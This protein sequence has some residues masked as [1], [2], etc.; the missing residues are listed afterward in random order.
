MATGTWFGLQRAPSHR[1]MLATAFVLT[2][3][4]CRPAQAGVVQ[5]TSSS[6][7]SSGDSSLGF[8]A[9]AGTVYA[10]HSV[11]FSSGS[12]TVGFGNTS[13]NGFEVDQANYNY[14]DTAFAN[15]TKLLGS[16]GY[17]GSGG[18]LTVTFSKAVA[19]FGFN[20]EDFY[21]G[22]YT[23]SFTA[24]NGATALGTF[25]ASGCDTSDGCTGANKLSFEGLA[26]SGGTQI[27][28]LV[29]TDDGGQN[30]LMLGNFEFGFP[31]T[32]PVTVPEPSSLALFASA[33]AVVALGRRRRS[34]PSIAAA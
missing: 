8:P 13:G 33:A 31:G 29:L 4:A 15:N 11:A 32:G 23:I 22:A 6:G 2:S 7:L 26:A 10:G 12:E 27:T 20:I 24:F 5:I 1:A 30:N 17:Q 21:E 28:S 25:T 19:E 3:I 34:S 18:P 9:A 16:G 14:G